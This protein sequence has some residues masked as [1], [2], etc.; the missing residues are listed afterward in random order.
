MF[1][2]T[3]SGVSADAF[4]CA[5]LRA[6]AAAE[7]DRL[8]VWEKGRLES[9]FVVL[10]GAVV[11]LVVMAMEKH[12]TPLPWAVEPTKGLPFGTLRALDALIVT[13]WR[14]TRSERTGRDSVSR[15]ACLRLSRMD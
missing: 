2:A 5:I 11:D 13:N 14:G 12:R 15:T 3:T 7:F 9:S 4:S 6:S 1:F 10:E 8:A